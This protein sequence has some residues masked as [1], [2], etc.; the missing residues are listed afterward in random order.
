MMKFGY[1]GK[2]LKVDLTNNRITKEPSCDYTVKFIGGRG[3]AA[4][5]YWDNVKHDSGSLDPDNCLICANGLL[6]GFPGLASSRCC[7]CGKTRLNNKDGF[8]YGSLGGKW[9]VLLKFAGYDGLIVTGKAEKPVYLMI[10]NNSALIKDASHLWG[11]PTFDTCR[12]IHNE[13]GKKAGILT[14]GP[15][16]ENLVNFSSLVADDGSTVS[17]GLGL[18]MGGKYLKAVV[19]SGD[20]KPE[21]ADS[22]KLK[23]IIES[24]RDISKNS[25][26]EKLPWIIPGKNKKQICFECG[27]GCDRRR[28]K[29]EKGESYKF[30]CQA[31]VFYMNKAMGFYNDSIRALEAQAYATRLCDNYGL[32]TAVI[33]PIVDFLSLCFKNHIIDNEKTGMQLSKIGSSEFIEDL[34]KKITYREGFGNQ[35]CTGVIKT[36]ADIGKEAT[37]ILS[38]CVA[39]RGS[40]TKDY[41]PRMIIT[42]SLMYATEPRRPIQ[43]LHE[44]SRI[45]RIWLAGITGNDSPVIS[46]DQ[47]IHIAE[48]FWGSAIAA[49]FSTNEGKAMAA[50]KIQDRTY[51]K[52]SLIL[53]DRSWSDFTRSFVTTDSPIC[54]IYN[55]VTG[56]NYSMQDLD[57]IGERIFNL[58]RSILLS[59]GWGGREGDTLLDYFHEKKLKIGEL[60]FNPGCLVPGNKGNGFSRAGVKIDRNEFEDLKSEY[61]KLRCWDVKNGYPTENLLSSLGIEDV[62]SKLNHS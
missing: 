9:G 28:Y 51:L 33:Q 3:L 61:Y 56:N 38:D 50:K 34:I 31:A 55:A 21:A 7:I 52:E 2:I 57:L 16:G 11:K 36:A 60:P 27:L 19:V 39:T 22:R 59:E 45:L 26:E 29:G 37:D 10:D 47:F 54:R 14:V 18:L 1:T 46:S 42:T 62:T 48:S 43:Q 20:E 32:D 23:S 53:C 40:E 24:I 13:A 58:Q 6:T 17:G 5:L 35:L 12:M 30:L 4:K 49:D 8:C 41:D 25:P 15:A 44:I